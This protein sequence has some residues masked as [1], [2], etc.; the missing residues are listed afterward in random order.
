MSAIVK[1]RMRVHIIPR[2]SLRLPSMISTSN[3]GRVAPQQLSEHT[4]GSNVGQFDSSRRDE[5]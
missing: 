4:F 2:M 3:E 1:R 5:L